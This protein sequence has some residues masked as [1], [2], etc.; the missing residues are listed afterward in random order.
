MD[1]G[2]VKR[3]LDSGVYTTVGDFK[4]DVQLIFLN[5]RNEF[6]NSQFTAIPR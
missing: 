5:C 6:L 1:L 3:N 4:S 2:T